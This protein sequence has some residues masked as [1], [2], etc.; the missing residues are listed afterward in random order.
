M[1]VLTGMSWPGLAGEFFVSCF[2]M[3]SSG[4]AWNSS[5]FRV[6]SRMYIRRTA[7]KPADRGRASADKLESRA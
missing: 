1:R 2:F 3:D 5:I 4:C 7:G 6:G